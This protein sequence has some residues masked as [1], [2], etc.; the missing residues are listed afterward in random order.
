MQGPGFNPQ[1][2]NKER[3]RE[4]ED[5]EEEKEEEEGKE[6]ED[7]VHSSNFA[8]LIIDRFQTKHG[9]ACLLVTNT[10]EAEAKGL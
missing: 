7:E 10:Q 8:E 9:D 2:S 3:Q 1:H 5:E 4:E 6:E